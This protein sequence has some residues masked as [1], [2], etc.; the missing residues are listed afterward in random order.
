MTASIKNDGLALDSA[1]E[2]F[3]ADLE[4]IKS[5]DSKLGEAYIEDLK[6][7]VKSVLV[8]EAVKKGGKIEEKD[9][10]LEKEVNNLVAFYAMLAENKR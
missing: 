5:I 10:N 9:L 1:L 3:K 7:G 6:K 8:D 2:Q 4:F